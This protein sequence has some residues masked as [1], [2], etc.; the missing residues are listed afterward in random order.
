MEY[1]SA[2]SKKVR[3]KRAKV[4]PTGPG[5]GPGKGLAKDGW[6]VRYEYKA[7][8]FAEIRGELEVVRTDHL[9]PSVIGSPS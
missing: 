3:K 2:H 5:A 6:I 8:T 1:Y 4:P 9:P 7:G